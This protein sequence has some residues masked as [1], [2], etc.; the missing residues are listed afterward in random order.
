[1]SRRALVLRAALCFAFSSGALAAGCSS[2]APAGPTPTRAQPAN[3]AAPRVFV[4]GLLFDA[5]PGGLAALGTSPAETSFGDLA[6]RT[7]ARHVSSFGALTTSDVVARL[8]PA[9]PGGAAPGDPLAGYR[10]EITPHVVEDD[11]VRLKVDLEL[12]GKEAT[13]TVVVPDKELL[14]LGTEVTIEDRRVTLLVRPHVVRSDADLS[15]LYERKKADPRGS[16][17]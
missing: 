13:T 3:E 11:R 2:T 5:P 6:A 8:P 16:D 1:M 12:G 17:E 15:A 14:V 4:E 7:G 9:D 10:L